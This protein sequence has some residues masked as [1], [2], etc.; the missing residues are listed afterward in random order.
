MSFLVRPAAVLISRVF[1]SD[2]K[3]GEDGFSPGLQTGESLVCHVDLDSLWMAPWDACRTLGTGSRP[4]IAIC[5]DVLC[6]IA[7]L[8][9]MPVFPVT[10]CLRSFR[11]L[12]KTWVLDLNTGESKA[13]VRMLGDEM[14]TVFPRPQFPPCG[15]R[16][17]PSATV[18]L[19]SGGSRRHGCAGNGHS[20][21]EKLRDRSG[22]SP[23]ELYPGRE[24]RGRIGLSPG[25][26]Y[27]G[28]ELR[29]RAGLYKTGF[30]GWIA[31]KQIQ[32]QIHTVADFRHN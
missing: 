5:R 20:P 22:F 30:V 15:V 27:P 14:E 19:V 13:P 21:S 7:R 23:G 4:G 1:L 8:S 10:G 6:G 16:V 26:P 18:T 31:S 28:R 3:F 32:I 24:V 17:L 9:S 25:E 11:G 12:G 2:E 29:G